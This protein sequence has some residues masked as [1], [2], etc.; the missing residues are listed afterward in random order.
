MDL[1]YLAT[2]CIVI[3]LWSLV[4]FGMV[5]CLP[6]GENFLMKNSLFV[7]GYFMILITINSLICLSSI[8]NLSNDTKFM[9]FTGNFLTLIMLG[10]LLFAFNN[11]KKE[12]I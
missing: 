6:E 7:N 8:N 12:E 1:F 9:L 11:S 4:I 2:C 10:L 5:A 3:D